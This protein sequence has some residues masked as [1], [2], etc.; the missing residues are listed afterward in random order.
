MGLV[1]LLQVSTSSDWKERQTRKHDL[2]QVCW[3]GG[4]ERTPESEGC[5]WPL[6]NVK[7]VSLSIVWEC[8]SGGKQPM[9][10]AFLRHSP[11]Y[12]GEKGY[13]TDPAVWWFSQHSSWMSLREPLVSASLPL[14]SQTWA[15]VPVFLCLFSVGV[16]Y[17]TQVILLACQALYWVP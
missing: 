8:T 6:P 14:R 16:R 17:L 2:E 4:E 11:S 15:A 12:F 1:I 3:A 5:V 10:D 9:S 7:P 13:L